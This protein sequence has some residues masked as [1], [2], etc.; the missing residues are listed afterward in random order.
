MNACAWIEPYV[1]ISFGSERVRLEGPLYGTPSDG[2]RV[3][4]AGDLYGAYVEGRTMGRRRFVDYVLEIAQ[5]TH[6][7]EEAL[8]GAV[9][10]FLLILGTP[11][12]VRIYTSPGGQGLFYGKVEDKVVISDMP[13]VIVRML[14][15]REIEDHEVLQY[16]LLG[17]LNPS[18][19]RHIIRGVHC[20]MGGC[21]LSV[22]SRGQ[23]DVRVY[24]IQSPRKRS[25]T[26]AEY[27][28][29]LERQARIVVDECQRKKQ[30]IYS[31]FSGG[32]D[33][34]VATLAV[35]AAGGDIQP[36]TLLPKHYRDAWA[37]EIT[38][39]ESMLVSE[40]MNLPTRIVPFD[41]F[42][43]QTVEQQFA[44]VESFSTPIASYLQIACLNDPSLF[45]GQA[46][47]VICGDRMDV[48]MGIA[49]THPPFRM[50]LKRSG[51]FFG[52]DKSYVLASQYAQW[53]QA[54]I[55]QDTAAK[56]ALYQ[57]L[58]LCKRVEPRIPLPRNAYE[59]LVFMILSSRERVDAYE[60]LR[61]KFPGGLWDEHAEY[62][63]ETVLRYLA[64]TVDVEDLRRNM[65]SV[66]EFS[67]I[68]RRVAYAGHY[69][70][71]NHSEY[72]Q[73][74]MMGRYQ[75]LMP[76]IQGPMLETLSNSALGFGDVSRP[77][78]NAHRYFAQR[79]GR[80]YEQVRN[81]KWPEARNERLQLPLEN[82]QQLYENSGLHVDHMM[83]F[84]NPMESV[85]LQCLSKNS[86]KEVLANMYSEIW[87]NRRGGPSSYL[88]LERLYGLESYVRT[89]V[90]A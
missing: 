42:H 55:L 67:A 52:V 31:R 81:G 87:K 24:V 9:G 58:R 82:Y 36:I 54:T 17:R 20:L 3:Y 8:R 4:I 21:E 41:E 90:G 72:G 73:A 12:C 53:Y 84:M 38:Y 69:W 68:A 7:V 15:S 30:P 29:A 78:R 40:A 76:A 2:T 83:A 43:P 14:P 63:S 57:V 10:D 1:G 25:C 45:D 64:G 33:S 60:F 16:A 37:Y 89:A 74:R 11:Q 71:V 23:A 47:L 51:V 79:T 66:E 5:Q 61:A 49:H 27:V 48:Q 19:F 65:V 70:H 62:K 13:E 18:P 26:Y 44:W 22:S 86:I 77:K 39:R 28:D 34:T 32:I 85:V 35:Q 59:Y 6:R 50:P 88:T 80:N 46:P 56:R 75:R